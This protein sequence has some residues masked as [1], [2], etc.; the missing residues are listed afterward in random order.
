MIGKRGLLILFPL[1]YYCIGVCVRIEIAGLPVVNGGHTF[2]MKHRTRG[3]G[4]GERKK[5]EV[6]DKKIFLNSIN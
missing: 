6:E 5:K 1:S 3:V 2:C 4:R